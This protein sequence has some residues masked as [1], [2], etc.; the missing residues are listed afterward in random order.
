MA[1]ISLMALECPTTSR[2]CSF[3]LGSVAVGL[4][5][6][7]HGYRRH[8]PELIDLIELFLTQDGVHEAVSL[9]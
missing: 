4:I 7:Q 1:F 8:I 2:F 6:G 5:F 3:Q 9:Y